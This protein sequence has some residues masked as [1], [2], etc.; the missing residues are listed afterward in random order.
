MS[1]RMNAKIGVIQM[2]TFNEKSKCIES[3]SKKVS[4]CAL[5]NA[6]IAILPEIFNG[7]Y[8]SSLFPTFAEPKGGETYQALSKMASDNHIYLIA[9][10]IPELKNGK[11]YNTSFVFDYNGQEIARHRKVHLFDIDIEGGQKFKES[12]TLT[13]GNDITVFDIDLNRIRNIDKPQI[14][15]IGI[16]ICFDFRFPELARL[17]VQRGATVLIVPA[18]FNMTTGPI[19]WE[20][21][22]RQRA[23]D[24]QCFTVGVAPARNVNSCYVSYA[25]SIVVSPWGD[26]IY[27]SDEKENLD[28]INLDL[29]LVQKVRK[30]LPLLSSRRTD[31]YEMRH[32]CQ[33]YSICIDNYKDYALQ[34][35]LANEDQILEIFNLLV[36][37]TDD[38][39]QKGIQ[40]WTD[41][42]QITDI[43]SYVLNNEV[44]IMKKDYGKIIAICCLKRENHFTDAFINAINN[45]DALYLTKLAILPEFQKKGIGAVM[46]NMIID[47]ARARFH[48]NIVL[49]CYQGNEKLKTFYKNLGFTFVADIPEED[50]FV[51][52]FRFDTSK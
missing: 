51:S 50:Y 52:I 47:Q 27:R 28:I 1:T 48:K 14:L 23:V 5:K 21:M 15:T 11:I 44:Y 4:E 40:Q 24:N 35:E 43:R 8:S 36:R 9:G 7:P 19:H 6:E 49:D 31:I 12:D 29:T 10:S 30:Q 32:I 39:H 33:N 16:C 3:A 22:Y 45:E 42:W 41:E 37:V 13:P 34:F 26:V 17:M 18:A 20:L 46:V 25:N 2:M 38:L